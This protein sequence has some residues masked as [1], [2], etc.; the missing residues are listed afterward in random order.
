MSNLAS[1]A[2]HSPHS[3][4]NAMWS[5]IRF[6]RSKDSKGWALV[7]IPVRIYPLIVMR[8]FEQRAKFIDKH[9]TGPFISLLF[10]APSPLA[11]KLASVFPAPPGCEALSIAAKGDRILS[12]KAAQSPKAIRQ[13][14]D[15][16]DQM[17]MQ[18]GAA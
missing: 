10:E 7:G 15:P 16:M 3:I 14:L 2:H 12:G 1:T 9:E 13:N 4:A 8:L 6:R 5:T 17:Q 11:A 18:P